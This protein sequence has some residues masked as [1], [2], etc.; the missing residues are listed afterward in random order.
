MNMKRVATA[1]R[2]ATQ[3]AKDARAI[4]IK[5]LDQEPLASKKRAPETAQAL[6]TLGLSLASEVKASPRWR[7]PPAVAS[8]EQRTNVTLRWLTIR[9]SW[10]RGG[11]AGWWKNVLQNSG[12]SNIPRSRDCVRSMLA[13]WPARFGL[14]RK[15]C[16]T[17]SH[18]LG[19]PEGQT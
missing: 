8:C 12:V 2:E 14:L 9:G 15:M 19:I 16:I 7:I 4:T 10:E 1:A 11:S 3:T 5:R 17:E 13:N 6:V 18:R